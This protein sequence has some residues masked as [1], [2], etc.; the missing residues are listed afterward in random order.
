MPPPRSATMTDIRLRPLVASDEAFLRRLYATVRAPELALTGWSDEQKSQFCN[1]QFD[2]QDQHY[3]SHYRDA[4]FQ[5]VEQLSTHPIDDVKAIGRVYCAR[6]AE[7]R[8]DRLMEMS[9]VPEARGRGI[10]TSLIEAILAR[11]ERSGHTVSLH[12][13]PANPARRLY[14]RLG[15]TVVKTGDVYD[16]MHWQPTT[17]LQAQ[18]DPKK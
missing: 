7:S 15:F 5:I 3:R 2:A 9:L 1:M 16:Q 10:G 8:E 12:V 14:A 18:P 17:E 13:E 11:A 4:E 6:L